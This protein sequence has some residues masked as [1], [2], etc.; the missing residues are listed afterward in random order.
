[1]YKNLKT[2]VKN[3][4]WKWN[5]I[6]PFVKKHQFDE[7][8]KIDVIKH[9]FKAY[10]EIHLVKAKNERTVGYDTKALLENIEIKLNTENRF[11]YFL[12]TS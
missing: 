8:G 2:R 5:Y 7:K 10:K 6:L 9:I 3:D 1:M 4:L 11:V 12:D